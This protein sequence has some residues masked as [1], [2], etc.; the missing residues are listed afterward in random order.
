MNVL[1]DHCVPVRFGR[2]LEGHRVST[3]AKEGWAALRNGEL[4]QAAQ[5]AGFDC[6][7]SV[8]RGF[9]HQHNAARLPVAVIVVASPSNDLAALAACA[10]AVRT[11]LDEI[12]R[13]ELRVVRSGADAH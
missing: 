12:T 7:I 6:V 10:P 3:A 11:A 9:A 5:A 4:M 1:L 8:D 13:G 2:L